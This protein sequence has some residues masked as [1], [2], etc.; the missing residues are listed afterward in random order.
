[1]N[2]HDELLEWASE[3]G[4]GSWR[5]WRDASAYLGLEPN[6]AARELSA[7]GHVEFDW[8]D[9]RFACAPPTAILTLRSSGCL[10][11]TGARRRGFRARLEALWGEGDYDVDVR[12]PVPQERGPETWLVEAEMSEIERFCAAATLELHVDSGRRI[13]AALPQATLEAVGVEER[14][15]DRFPRKWF[16]P[17]PRF[18]CFRSG[19][20]SGAADGL[21][22]VEEH[23]RDV[24]FV[25]RDARWWRIPTR[26]Y[27]PYIAYPEQ[28]FIAYRETLGFL[29]VDTAAPLPPLVARA[30]TLQSGRLPKREGQARHIYVNIDPVLVELIERHLDAYVVWK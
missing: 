8:A 3:V 1:V 10:L 4:S 12:P 28:S 18:R 30:A 9:N 17:D 13:A 27:G 29:T 26:E 2:A 5:S 20:A 22:W 19:D 16:D 24:A 15:D 6:A 7:L 21:W 14:P 25:R 11:L 23:R